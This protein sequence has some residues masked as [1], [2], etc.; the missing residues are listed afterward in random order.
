MKENQ[1]E[2]NLRIEIGKGTKAF[3]FFVSAAFVV[4]CAFL[5]IDHFSKEDTKIILNEMQTTL[6]QMRNEQ[7]ITNYKILSGV[8]EQA[9][10]QGDLSLLRNDFETFKDKMLFN[11]VRSISSE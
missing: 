4:Q 7:T 8:G 11:R 3:R 9:R 10:L 2:G 1:D 5:I 6:V